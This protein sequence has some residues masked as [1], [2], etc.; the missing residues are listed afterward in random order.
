MLKA[1]SII[2]LLIIFI[3]SIKRL[4]SCNDDLKEYISVALLLIP[5]IIYILLS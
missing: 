1:Y 4:S 3:S 5:P 2:V